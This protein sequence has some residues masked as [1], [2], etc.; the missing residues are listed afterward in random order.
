[1]LRYNLGKIY[2]IRGIIKPFAFLKKNGFTPN[3]AARYSKDI[4]MGMRT[5]LL[6]RI[7]LILNCTP[8]DIMEWI[9]E[10]GDRV[11]A[12][13]A[14]YELNKNTGK[15]DFLDSIHDLPLDKMA[16]I[17]ELIQNEIKKD[18]GNEEG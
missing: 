9:P 3:Q 17:G 1:M 15:L 11:P 12:D 14:L 16:E 6:E 7:C 13:H 4:V 10:K 18:T 5:E 8:H 2:K